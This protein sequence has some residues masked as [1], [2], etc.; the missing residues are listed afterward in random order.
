MGDRNDHSD[1]IPY[2]IAFLIAL[3]LINILYRWGVGSYVEAI[4]TT[5]GLKF[6]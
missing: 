1:M 6:K 2:V 4:E 5:T 3:V